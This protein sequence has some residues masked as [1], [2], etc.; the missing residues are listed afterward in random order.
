MRDSSSAL[1][2]PGNGDTC[3]VPVAVAPASLPDQRQAWCV[4]FVMALTLGILFGSTLNSFGVFT[5]P[6][7]V[8]FAASHEQVANASSLFM[9]SMTVAMP[10]GGWLMERLGPRPVMVSGALL[11][12]AGYF[13]GGLSQDIDSLAMWMAISGVGIGIS[14]YVPAIAMVL[15]WVALPRQGLAVGLVLAGGS[16]GAIVFPPFLSWIIEHYQVHDAMKLI[17]AM[18]LLIVVPALLWQAR[19]PRRA[20]T[21]E[22]GGRGAE[23]AG[24][25]LAAALRLPGYWCW[26]GMQILLT[27]SVLGIFVNIVPFLIRTGYTPAQA[28][29]IFSATS[30]CALIGHFVFGFLSTRWDAKSVLLMANVVGFLGILALLAVSAGWAGPVAVAVFALGWGATFNL[31]NQF[32]PMLMA[33]MVGEREFATLLGLGSLLAGVGSAFSPKLVGYLL[34]VTQSYAPSLLFCATCTVLSLPLIAWLPRRTE[35]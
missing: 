3:S 20:N 1:A 22:Q 12:S 24:L 14:T 30:T 32:S 23:L 25:P 27:L 31:V 10:V 8:A 21:P 4:V 29:G 34:D 33:R 18:M 17:G 16:L 13:L 6:L 7:T 19:M 11:A 28:A 15:R 9:L 26:V 2:T 35:S 5:L